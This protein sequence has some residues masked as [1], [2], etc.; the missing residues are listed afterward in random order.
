[1]MFIK[2]KKGGAML[3]VIFAVAIFMMGNLFIPSLKDDISQVRIDLNCSNSSALSDGTKVLC[4]EIDLTIP[5]FILL[6]LS[7][8]GGAIGFIL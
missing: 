4:S 5:Y 3:G 2:N 6:I 7:L 1:M 8:I